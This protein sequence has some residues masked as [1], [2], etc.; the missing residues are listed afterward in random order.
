MLARKLAFPLSSTSTTSFARAFATSTLCKARAPALGDITHDGADAFNAK[1]KEFRDGLEAQKKKKE[2][3][4]SQLLSVDNFPSSSPRSAPES[5]RDSSSTPSK[6]AEVLSTLGLGSLSTH[7][8]AGEA[9]RAETDTSTRKSGRLTNLIYGTEEGRQMD[10]DLERSFSQVLARGK[11]VHTIVF[12]EVKPDKVEEY[13]ELV[14]SWYPKMANTQENHVNLVGSWRTEVGDIDTFGKIPASAPS[15]PSPT[16]ASAN[17]SSP[18]L[19]IP[20]IPRV[21]RFAPQDAP[22]SRISSFRPE[23]AHVDQL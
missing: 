9:R 20:T 8:D 18:H 7:S 5:A 4:D 17:D 6:A 3:A 23:N 16:G 10:R 12:H 14:G 13:V 1:Q 15:P 22:P 2:Q 21:P 11:Y 19:G